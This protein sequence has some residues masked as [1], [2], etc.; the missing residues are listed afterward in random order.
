[1]SRDSFLVGVRRSLAR[2]EDDRRLRRAVVEQVRR[3][4]RFDA[5]AWLLTD[6]DTTVGTAPL[7]EVPCLNQLSRLVALRY[8]SGRRWTVAEPGV[9]YRPVMPGSELARF[10]AGYGTYDVV[11]LVFADRFGWWGFLDL[12]R[13]GG[14]FDAE[15]VELLGLLG[16]PVTAAL[17][18]SRA[19]T[20]VPPE[21]ATQRTAG[22]SVLLL[23]PDLSLRRQTVEAESEFRALLP[24]EDSRRPVPAAAYNVAAQLLA[25][26]AGID[27][28]RPLARTS[29][30][31]GQ[32]ISVQAGRL[33]ED[34]A[35][36]I[37]P[38][39]Q[40]DRWNLFCRTHGLS[41][42][43]TDV[44]TYLAEGDDTRTLAARLHLSEYTVQDH[45]KSAFAKTCVRSRR[46]LVALARGG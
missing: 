2:V 22:R 6:P 9:P 7:A 44:V 46:E 29:V 12:W 42:R 14:R 32:W 39:E 20:F 17:R 26:E 1:V 33:G 18:E 13:E 37:G 45:L 35:V 34:I 16:Q 38:V 30:A 8:T 23:G 24:T 25:V 19:A 21:G 31:P 40:R 28:H 27:A 41:D 4:V 15:E 3:A 36:T 43:E 11:S 10:L 5:F